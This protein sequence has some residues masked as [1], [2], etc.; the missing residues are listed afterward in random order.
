MKIC[1]VGS[2]AIG[3]SLGGILS[4]G[5]LDVHL[6]DKWQAHVDA[7][8]Q[9]G[10]RLR[11]AESERVVKVTAHADCRRVGVA[12][13]VIVLVK[14]F[15]T[16]Q[17]IEECGPLLGERTVVLSLQNG[18]GNEDI[19]IDVVGRERVLG[20]RTYAGGVL[21]GPGHVGAGCKGKPTYLGELDGAD[22]ERLRCVVEEFNRGGLETIASLN[23]VGMMWDKLMINIA[24]GALCGV[25]GLTFGG[26]RQVPE[27]KQVALAAVGEAITVAETMG[28][29]LTVTDPEAIWATAHSGL[30][31]DF[32]ASILQDLEKGRRTEVDFI[33]GSVVRLGE[34]L[35]VPTPVN[36]ALVATIKGIELRQQQ[37]RASTCQ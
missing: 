20:G 28:I 32:K 16:R 5:G 10:L 3:S 15:H 21:L 25:T 34:K 13:L 2:G 24:T 29:T 33:G 9:H 35:G 26:L 36:R 1:F 11:E 19:L 4:E 37:G 30:P 22:S 23:I 7:M 18:L 6:V 8:N 14:S 17:A 12:D 27:I 31:H